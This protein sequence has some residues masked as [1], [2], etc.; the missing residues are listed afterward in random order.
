[1]NM[2]KTRLLKSLFLFI[3]VAIAVT[4]CAATGPSYTSIKSTI[5]QL[6]SDQARLYFLRES[7]LMASAIAARIQINGRKFADLY[8]GGFVYTD[9][10]ADEVFIMV[11]ASLNPGE[12]QGTFKLDAG[13]NHYFFVTPN[14][15]KVM[16]GAMFGLMGAAV[17]KGGPFIVYPIPED[18]ALEKLKTMKLGSKSGQ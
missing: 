4:G 16:A 18:M 15:N 13:K 11:D 17:T 2:N 1:M 3:G 5:P 14:S 10:I 6:Q 7:T 12:W 8:S 9:L